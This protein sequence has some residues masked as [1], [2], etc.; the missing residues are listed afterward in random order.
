MR[1]SRLLFLP[2]LCTLML[3]TACSEYTAV[4]KSNDYEYKYEAAKA[5]YAEGH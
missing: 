5:L 3:L 4:L 2:L 1:I